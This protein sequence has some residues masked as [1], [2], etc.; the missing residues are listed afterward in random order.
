V[1]VIYIII[2]FQ[3]LARAA[4]ENEALRSAFHTM[5]ERAD[6]GPLVHQLRQEIIHLKVQWTHKVF[7]GT[8]APDFSGQFFTCIYRSR[9]NQEVL[10]FIIFSEALYLLCQ[11]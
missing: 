6:T 9:P 3:I 5:E 11:F 2:I 1:C 4:K 10:L 7:P 8:I